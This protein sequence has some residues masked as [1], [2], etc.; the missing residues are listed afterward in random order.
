MPASNTDFQKKIWT[1]VGIVALVVVII[2]LLKVIFN[3]L[4]LIFAAALIAIYFVGLAG[5]IR[6]K[7]PISQGVSTAIS[8]IGSLALLVGFFVLAGNSIAQQASEL[9]ETLPSAVENV[10][11]SLSSSAIGSRVLE[12]LN[13]DD[14]S[15]KT[16]KVVQTFFA[17]TFGVLGDIYVV[18]FLSIFFTVAPKSYKDGMIKLMP[19]SAKKKGES[20]LENLV[21][22]LKR[23]LKG[24]IFA[25]LVVFILTSIGLVIIGVPMWLVLALIAGLLNFIPNFG[26]LIAMIPAVLVGYLQS[27]TTALVVAGLYLLVQALES[28][29]ITPQIQKKLLNI[30]FAM[31]LIT[32]LIMGVLTGGWGLVLATPLMVVMMVLLEDLYISKQ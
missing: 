29:L 5:L 30:P 24:Q 20:V 14:M 4:L 2:W 27:P 26:P 21:T 19:T 32:Q 31:I 8:I 18:I 17:S 10:K 6:K 3:V 15:S 16:S 9:R 1:A 23:W 13:S 22:S 25:M 12:T 11:S 7:I 28:N